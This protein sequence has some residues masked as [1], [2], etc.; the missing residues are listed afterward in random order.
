MPRGSTALSAFWVRTLPGSGPFILYLAAFRCVVGALTGENAAMGAATE[1]VMGF[2]TLRLRD[3]GP[4][5]G[6]VEGLLCF[7]LGLWLWGWG[8]LATDQ[9]GDVGK[10]RP[11]RRTA[12]A[13]AGAFGPRR[14]V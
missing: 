11:K 6:S 5:F 2:D 3:V 10:R 9:H 8:R 13:L 1:L 4:P 12:H 7:A 14:R